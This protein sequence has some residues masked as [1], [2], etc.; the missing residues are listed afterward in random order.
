LVLITSIEG[1]ASQAPAGK[2]L[3]PRKGSDSLG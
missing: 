3:M 1:D 2:K